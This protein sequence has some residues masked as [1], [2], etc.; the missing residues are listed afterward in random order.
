GVDTQPAPAPKNPFVGD[1][2]AALAASA[3][4]VDA[5]Y[6]TPPQHHNTIELFSTTAEWHGEEL[7]LHEPRH[8]V[9]GLKVGVAKA[10]GIDSDLVR[11]VSP[12]VGGAF[13]AKAL[14]T[15]RTVLVAMAAKRLGRPVRVADT[16]QQCFT[17]ATFR[18]ETRQRVRLGADAAGQFQA[19]IHEGFELNSRDDDFIVAGVK[20]SAAMYAIPHIQSAI[21]TVRADRQSAGFMRAPPEVPYVFA[22]ESAVDELAVALGM[23]PVELRRRNDTD[24]EPFTGARFTSRSLMACYDRAAARFGWRDRDPRVGAMVDGDDLVGFGC[25]TAFYPTHMAPATAKVALTARGAQVE[26]AAHDV[27]TGAYTVVAQVAAAGLGLPVAAIEVSLGD[28]KLTPGPVA[29]GSVTT[30]SVGSAVHTA[31]G[32]LRQRLCR[33][34][35]EMAGPLQGRD[36]QTLALEDGAVVGADGARVSLATLVANGD[37]ASWSVVGEWA[38]LD[39]GK[40]AIQTLYDG[41]IKIVGGTR[42][43]RSMYAFG[44]EF[45]EVRVNR[46]TREIRVP[47]AVG[48]FAAGRI[49][50]QKTARS[51]YLGGMVWGIGSALH[52]A[53]EIDPAR[54]RYVNDNL[55]EY[56]IPVNADVPHIEVELVEEEDRE[57]NPLGVKG[58]GEVSIVGTAAAIAN[59]VYHATGVRVRRLP[60]RCEDL[61]PPRTPATD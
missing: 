43:D 14:M 28:S 53:T 42:G 20:N 8:C 1:A 56:L 54:G 15:A 12:F 40:A 57:V 31:C 39:T 47:R 26:C 17:T 60:I 22:M 18:A 61:L 19:L 41:V 59:A 38:P 7:V 36:P 35:V 50:N 25:A 58:I 11:V 2:P 4:A 45:V 29:G 49:L 55:G 48:A 46:Y 30:A 23:D 16:R 9:Y 44:A 3:V 6:Q 32:L 21:H 27:G 37:P 33:T 24:R 51:Q 5:A 34:A 52:E 10:L 13:G